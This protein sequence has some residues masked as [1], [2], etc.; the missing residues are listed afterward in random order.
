MRTVQHI[1]NCKEEEDNLIEPTAMV[2]DAL[3]KLISVNL[4]YLIVFEKEKYRGIFSERDYTRKLV[5]Q[6]K[7]SRDTQVG[8]VMTVDVPEVSPSSTVEECMYQMNIRGARYLAVYTE[9]KFEG[10]ITIH[11]LLRQ[12]IANKHE[13]FDDNLASSLLDSDGSSKI[14]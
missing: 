4:S 12:V 13:V 14:F 7:S 5:L 3:R 9:E 1:L 11:D 10:I 2:I 8:D 6:N